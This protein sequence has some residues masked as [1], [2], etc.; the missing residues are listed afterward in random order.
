MAVYELQVS[1]MTCD[2]CAGAVEQAL[3][4]V[5]G[6]KGSSVSYPQS[7]ARVE[8]GEGVDGQALLNALQAKGYG[9]QLL[10]NEEDRTAKGAPAGRRGSGG[11]TETVRP[12]RNSSVPT[13]LRVAIIGSGGAAFA[14]AIRASE[15]GAQVTMIERGTTGGTCVNVGCV[16]SKIMIRSAHIAHLR[17]ESPFDAGL[18]PAPSLRV[19]RAALLKQQQERVAELRHTKYEGIVD[20]DPNIN[21]IRGTAS[22]LDAHTLRVVRED[23]SEQ[24]IG[25]DGAFIAT[26]ASP[27]IPPVAGL[28]GTPYWTSVEALA[29]E[30]VPPRLTVIGS[31]AVAVELAQAYARLGSRVTMLARRT[32]L[33][34]ED[35]EIGVTMS[36]VFADEG[37]RILER[38]QAERVA[39]QQGEFVLFSNDGEVRSEKLLVA[40]GRAANTALLNAH[41]PGVE[42]D[43]D[44]RVVVDEHLR[45]SNPN[46][47]AGG[48]CTSQPQFVYVAAAAGTRAAINMMGGD[49]AL[50]LTAMPAVIFT[51]PQIATVGLTEAQARQAG[52]E[53]DSRML[54][55]DNVPRALVNFDTRGFIKLVA[56]AGSGRLIGAQIVAAEGGEVVQAAALAIRNRMTVRDLADQLFP[57][58]TMVESLK[59]CA[60]TF[61]K[62][63]KQLSCCAG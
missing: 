15:E 23:G 21:L 14:A 31:S 47:Y 48:D 38:T 39:F 53:I 41:V 43:E 63:V 51:D 6:V 27:I 33:A 4:D 50:D 5:A 17:Q 56:E 20:S 34:H 13:R 36:K 28:A 11:T 45:T 49:A 16:P 19:D 3:A 12:T 30:S 37:I 44:G 29:A 8:A 1:G 46:I 55:L 35:P 32:L 26:G 2:H 10:R 52:V 59:L 62:D 54:T 22:F 58:L 25:F 40:T 61:F 57:Y 18:P 7:R 9:A 24:K 42:L 60:Q